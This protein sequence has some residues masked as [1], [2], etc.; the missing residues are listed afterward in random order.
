MKIREA[1]TEDLPNI[2][3]VLKA[4]LGESSSKKNSEVW[5]YKHVEN[6]FGKSLILIAEENNTIIGVRAFMRWEWKRGRTTYKTFRAVDTA[7]HPNHQGKGIFKKLTMSALEIA[8]NDGDFVFNTPNDQSRPGYLKMGW[9]VVDKINVVLYPAKLFG[10][11]FLLNT[12]NKD[13]VE[14]IHPIIFESHNRR[15]E[16]DTK[17][18]T[19][20]SLDYIKWRYINNPLQEYIIEYDQNYFLACYIKKHKFF[21]ELRISELL[22]HTDIGLNSARNFVSKISYGVKPLIISS[23]PCNDLKRVI[24]FR[25]AY[26]PVLTSR[27]LNQNEFIVPN[28]HDWDYALGDLE[29]F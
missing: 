14:E 22:Y 6:P 28:I 21:N 8:G 7:T 1:T 16:N 17:L 5:N 20:K 18:Y 4:S 10:S 19:P 11:D 9:K 27:S 15:L 12:R 13:Q 23:S 3:K 25:G 24:S 26:G 2:L 29:L